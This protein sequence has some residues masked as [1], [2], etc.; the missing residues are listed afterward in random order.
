MTSRNITYLLGECMIILALAL[1]D[2]PDLDK[3]R[4]FDNPGSIEILQETRKMR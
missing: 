3:V 1:L 4:N 2:F